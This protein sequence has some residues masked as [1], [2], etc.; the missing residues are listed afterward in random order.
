[1]TLECHCAEANGPELCRKDI[2]ST[3][4]WGTSVLS[5]E[6]TF[7]HFGVSLDS[8]AVLAG[9]MRS[10]CLSRNLCCWNSAS[11]SW[12]GQD[13]S[14]RAQCVPR[15]LSKQAKL[16]YLLLGKLR[17]GAAP[18][19]SECCLLFWDE[20]PSMVQAPVSEDPGPLFCWTGHL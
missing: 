5:T 8:H 2:L 9:G 14:F 13:C 17:L 11:C 4:T 3:R 7:Y 18:L 12:R 20:G 16:I 6:L 15:D 10:P 19:C 1:M